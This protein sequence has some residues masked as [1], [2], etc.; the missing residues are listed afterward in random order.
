MRSYR[1]LT[2]LI[3][4]PIISGCLFQSSELR[5]LNKKNPDGEYGEGIS[6]EMD[7]SIGDILSDPERYIGTDL[8]AEGSIVEVCPMRGCWI[9]V[10]DRDTNQSIRVKVTDGDI[11]FPLSSKGHEVR[12]EGRLSKL[13]F[14]E[15][16]ARSWKAHLEREKGNVVSPDSVTITDDDLVEYRIIGKGAQIYT[17][18]CEEK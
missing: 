5:M 7:T 8:V 10:E 11:V 14:T 1:N 16:Q 13:E 4:I 9:V 15:K 6:I 12:V 3:I 18:G 17:Y 2:L